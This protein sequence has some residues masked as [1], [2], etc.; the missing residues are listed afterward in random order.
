MNRFQAHVNFILN[1]SNKLM[2][3]HIIVFIS[4]A[5]VMMILVQYVR[6]ACMCC[7][8]WVS[9]IRAKNFHF[10]LCDKNF[11]VNIPYRELG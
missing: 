8:S 7:I 10:G 3:D 6:L 2:I 5:G 11:L 9:Y 4:V 1:H